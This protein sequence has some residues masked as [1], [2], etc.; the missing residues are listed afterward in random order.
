MAAVIAII[1]AGGKGKRMDILCQSRPKPALPFAATLRVVDFTLSNC[2]H[3]QINDIAV[4]TDY[5]RSHLE[6][7]LKCWHSANGVT[8]RFDILEP[9]NG[10]Y[11]GTADAVYQNLAYL[12]R[13]AADRVLI[14]AGDHVYRMDYRK[15]LAFHEQ[16][17]AD[18]T[19]GVAPVPIKQA[20][21]FGIVSA[22]TYGRILDFVEKPSLPMSNL[23]SMGIYI[24]NKEVLSRRLTEDGQQPDSPHD[25]GYAV[26][27]EMA[28][29][30]RVYAYRFDG[31]WRDIGTAEAYY[32]A[33]ME[34][35]NP[36]LSL[37]LNGTWPILREET[38]LPLVR[39]V[40]QGSVEN[41]LVGRGCVV[42]GRVE[43]SILS[44]GVQVEERAVV[45][46]SV[47]MPNVFVGHHSIVD[48]CILDEAVTVG[49]SCYIGFGAGIVSGDWDI[50][51]LGKGTTVPAGYRIGHNCRILPH[52]GGTDF[53]TKVIPPGTAVSPQ[54]G[55]SI[56]PPRET[57]VA[58][59]R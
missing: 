15:M 14:L 37:G 13:Q 12:Q 49:E 33:N 56:P 10:S 24:F 21:R 53:A 31:Y 9:Q 58:N 39:I 16:V 46:D 40:K 50:T 43:N 23:V 45:R 38:N 52:S 7:Y 18:V 32:A 6:S 22:D 59:E 20:H 47:L 26:I 36:K 30:D 27:P 1:L 29:R 25:F 57:V 35:T 51:V 19:V 2:I 41:S 34:F 55:G 48:S 42:K 54:S 3:S 28:K 5:Q 11:G 44:P 17:N 4:L 8:E